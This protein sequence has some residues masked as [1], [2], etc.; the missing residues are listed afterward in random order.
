MVQLSACSLLKPPVCGQD[1]PT[2]KKVKLAAQNDPPNSLCWKAQGGF[3]LFIISFQ[4]ESSWVRLCPQR[5][6]HLQ[7]PLKARYI[8]AAMGPAPAP[9]SSAGS[10]GPLGEKGSLCIPSTTVLKG[11]Q[12]GHCMARALQ[13]AGNGFWKQNGFRTISAISASRDPLHLLPTS[14]LLSTCHRYPSR[15]QWLLLHNKRHF[16]VLKASGS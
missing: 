5:M 16:F 4:L 12:L 8:T 15:Q 9:C 11:S 10:R 6:Q 1:W 13:T 3:F 7:R 14:H 2:S